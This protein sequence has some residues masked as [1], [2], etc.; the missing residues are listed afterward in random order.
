[1]E[2]DAKLHIQQNV[3]DFLFIKGWTKTKYSARLR[4]S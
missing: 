2:T 3:A 1:M 4:N